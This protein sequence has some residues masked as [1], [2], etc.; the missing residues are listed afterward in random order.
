MLLL[1]W[2]SGRDRGLEGW[3]VP[4]PGVAAG[5]AVG[6][7]ADT[8]SPHHPSLPLLGCS[9]QWVRDP[10]PLSRVSR[11]LRG[12]ETGSRCGLRE[13]VAHK[14]VR[15][16]PVGSSQ[17]RDQTHVPFNGRWTANPRTTRKSLLAA[18]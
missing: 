5:P 1:S 18:S 10:R 6:S 16:T 9:L 15:W 3:P 2:V 11:A 12:L 14:L 8:V 17:T 7:R 4:P 13:V